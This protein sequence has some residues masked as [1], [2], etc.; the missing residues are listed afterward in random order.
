MLVDTDRSAMRALLTMLALCLALPASAAADALDVTSNT[1][2]RLNPGQESVSVKVQVR[3]TNRKAPTFSIEPCS[4][5]SSQRCR[6]KT[7]YYWH[8][9]NWVCA[10]VGARDIRSSPGV[11]LR[12]AKSTKHYKCYRITFPN[13]HYGQTR[14]FDVK[15]TLP[16][17]KPRSKH[18]TRV[19]DAY[20]YFCWYGQPGDRGSVSVRMPPGYEATT[21]WGKTIT[22]SNRKGTT[23]TG[24]FDGDPGKFYACTDASKPSRMLRTKVKGPDGQRVTIEAWPEDPEWSKTMAEAV[25]RVLPRLERLL[26]EPMP[27]DTVTIREVTEQSLDGYGSEFWLR[28]AIIRLGDHIDSPVNLARGLAMAWFNHRRIRDTW[29]QIGLS[30]WAGHKASGEACDWPGTYPGK[31]KPKLRT[32]K[33]LKERPTE[34]LEAIV[35]W[36]YDAACRIVQRLSLI[37]I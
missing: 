33:R 15:Y 9:W 4:P 23:I 36:Q 7:T 25:E 10:P 34:K 14:R 29:L 12:L 5:G 32:W 6:F 37:H 19:L 24:R 18:E 22:K 21:W 11:R 16:G 13:L 20:S 17:G 2:Y 28:H 30:Y 27:L 31:G 35:D 26:G 8:E 3:M 1:S